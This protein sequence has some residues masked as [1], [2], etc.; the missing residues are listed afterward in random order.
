MRRNTA[1]VLF[2][3]ILALSGIYNFFDPLMFP[4]PAHRTKDVSPLIYPLTPYKAVQIIQR[5]PIDSIS[6]GTTL[7][8]S[9]QLLAHYIQETTPRG[10]KAIELGAGTG[11]V[12]ITLGILGWEVWAT[13]LSNVIDDVLRINVDRNREGT[14]T[15]QELDWCKA[16]W[17]FIHPNVSDTEVLDQPAFDLIV[18]ADGVYSKELINPLLRTLKSLSGP[19]CPIILLA[20]ERRDTAIIDSFFEQSRTLG[21]TSKKLNLRRILGRHFV[22]WGWTPNDYHSAEIWTMRFKPGVSS[23]K[24]SGCRDISKNIEHSAGGNS[25]QGAKEQILPNY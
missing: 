17:K 3:G 21:F 12:S 6:T 8:L 24:P 10:T 7:Y 16:T 14:I 19:R 4:L 18:C 9:S 25:A 11:L 2:S 15:V 1:A 13:D 22:R 23:T 20:F 5:S